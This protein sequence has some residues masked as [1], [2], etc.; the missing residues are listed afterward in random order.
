MSVTAWGYQGGEQESEP[1]SGWTAEAGACK[2]GGGPGAAIDQGE[3]R[4][5]CVGAMMELSQV[6][7]ENLSDA[8]QIFS[9][10]AQNILPMLSLGFQIKET[11]L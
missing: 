2:G 7:R 11:Q 9:S 10:Q 8:Q 3:V 4:A 1:P 6:S 5:G